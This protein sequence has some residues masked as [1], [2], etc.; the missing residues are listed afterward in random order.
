M[1]MET[2]LAL[3]AFAKGNGFMIASLVLCFGI[4]LRVAEI[5]LLG[6]KADLA[7]AKGDGTMQGV[8]TVFSRS[9]PAPGMVKKSAVTYIGGYVFHIGFFVA[10]FFLGQHI[11]LFDLAFGVSWPALPRQVVELSAIF[12]IGALIAVA[13]TRVM[14]P[15]RR[16]LTTPQDWLGIIVTALPLV[17]G[18]LAINHMVDPYEMIMALHILSV[19]LLMVVLPFT[20][21]AHAVTFVLSRYY[22]GSIAGRKG[23]AS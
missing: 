6:R 7:P 3:L 13:I 15:V 11:E 1:S 9:L 16:L 19:E 20:K 23:I 12:A 21:L 17:T 14:D 22:Q 10:L 8:R 4:V 5:I 18:F 2:A